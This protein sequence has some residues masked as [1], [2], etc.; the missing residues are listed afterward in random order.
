M[1]AI[2]LG[3]LI[4]VA[5]VLKLDVNLRHHMFVHDVLGIRMK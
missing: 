1:H 3:C 4:L 5:Y 2:V